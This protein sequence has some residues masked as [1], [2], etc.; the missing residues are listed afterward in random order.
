MCLH[1]PNPAS[2][3]F[4]AGHLAK[5]DPDARL[6]DFALADRNYYTLRIDPA[7]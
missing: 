4:L 2:S 1:Q 5:L 7:R 6:V 3:D